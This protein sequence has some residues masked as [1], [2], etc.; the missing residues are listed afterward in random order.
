MAVTTQQLEAL[1]SALASGTTRVSFNGR[2]VDYAT[3]SEIIKAID[4]V[5]TQ[6]NAQLGQISNRQVRIYATKGL[7]PSYLE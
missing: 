5:K 7:G 3:T 2:S 1:E 6:L 4:Y